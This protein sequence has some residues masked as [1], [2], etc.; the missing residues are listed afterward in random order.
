MGA[1][2]TYEYLWAD[3]KHKKPVAV[4]APEYVGLLMD[5]IQAK[6]DDEEIF[7]ARVDVPFPRTFQNEVKSLVYFLI[8]FYLLLL[9]FCLVKHAH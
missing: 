8:L 9:L 6:I 4:S 3:E 5:W 7:P 2:P 1:G